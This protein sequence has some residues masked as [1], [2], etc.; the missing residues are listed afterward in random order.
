MSVIKVVRPETGYAQIPNLFAEDPRLSEAAVAVGLFLATRWHGYQIR[1]VEIQSKF[2]ERPGK[3]RGREWWARVSNELK[4]ANYMWLNRIHGEDGKFASD[5]IFCILGLP[6]E[7]AARGSADAGSAH[8]G[9]ANTGSTAARSDSTYTQEGLTQEETTTT[10]TRAQRG[11]GGGSTDFSL[12]FERSTERH[13]GLLASLLRGTP[14][15]PDAIQNI[16]DELVG[17]LD[18]ASQG[19]HPGIRNV[20]GW[21][22]HMIQQ[23]QAGTFILD[24][25]RA[26]QIR[27]EHQA[28]RPSTSDVVKPPSREIAKAHLKMSLEDL[29]HRRRSK[30]S[31]VSEGNYD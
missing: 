9:S 12:I 15:E 17:V 11:G 25:G 13:R 10:T 8:I 20:R 6:D 18:A 27:R 16:L 31:P 5:W 7:Y 29:E 23:S 1:P 2:S 4:S 22:T 21:V 26:I 30:F 24:F 3:P 19:R 14:L 28:S